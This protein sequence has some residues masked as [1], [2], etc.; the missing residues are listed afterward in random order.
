MFGRGG[1]KNAPPGPNR[2]KEISFISL[3]SSICLLIL[4]VKTYWD[5]QD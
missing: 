1:A 3:Y 2:V 5:F 4:R